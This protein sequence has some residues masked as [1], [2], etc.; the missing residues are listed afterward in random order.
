MA[1]ENPKYLKLDGRLQV[2]TTYRALASTGLNPEV[3]MK[4]ET[5]LNKH[6]SMPHSADGYPVLEVN[7]LNDEAVVA[8]IQM[9]LELL[10]ED[11]VAEQDSRHAAR[12]LLEIMQ[13]Q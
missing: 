10:A 8:D 13:K 12:G 5:V 4:L 2:D 9:S 3:E 11:P 1:Q 6:D 7:L